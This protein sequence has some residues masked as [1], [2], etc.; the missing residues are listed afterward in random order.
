MEFKFF[1]DIYGTHN[2]AHC[3]GEKDTNNMTIQVM[4]KVTPAHAY[5]GTE[6]RRRYSTNP[7][8]TWHQHH[9]PGTELIPLV[10]EAEW[11]L[12]L[13]WKVWKF[14]PPTGIWSP[15]HTVRNKPQY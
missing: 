11:A 8:T 4:V 7:L 12:G 3:K 5:G 2:Y 10:Q 14:S 13:F 9:T 6:G 15:D 1:I